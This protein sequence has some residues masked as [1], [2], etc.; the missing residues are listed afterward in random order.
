MGGQQISARGLGSMISDKSRYSLAQFLEL[1]EIDF[2]EALLKK[3][4]GTYSGSGVGNFAFALQ[5][6]TEP[7]LT[8]LLSEIVA[9][10]ADLR[11]RVTP[12]R[13]DQR[14]DDLTRCLAADHV[15]VKG[16]SLAVHSPPP[17]DQGAFSE[18]FGEGFRPMQPDDLSPDRS[19]AGS[20]E[21]GSA[22]DFG[23]VADLV[24]EVMD[25]GTLPDAPLIS[26]PPFEQR[27]SPSIEGVAASAVAAPIIDPFAGRGLTGV[28][29]TGVV[30]SFADPPPLPAPKEAAPDGKSGR[31]IETSS[32]HPRN[33][34]AIDY[35]DDGLL[36][37]CTIC[38]RS[39]KST[40]WAIFPSHEVAVDA[41]SAAV[42]WDLGGYD[43]AEVHPA[44]KA[45]KGTKHYEHH[46]DWLFE[47]QLDDPPDPVQVAGLLQDVRILVDAASQRPVRGIGDNFPPSPIDAPPITLT[48]IDI[49]IQA[50]NVYRTVTSRDEEQTK[51]LEMVFR[52]TAQQLEA[53]T[54]WLGEQSVEF[55]EKIRDDAGTM[56]AE[57]LVRSAG[58]AACGG[59]FLLLAK[60][61]NAL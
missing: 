3:H 46:A 39:Q 51:L 22:Y 59:A 10:Q 58:P 9:T 7:Y 16:N 43:T 24:T 20:G 49:C 55:F 28:S 4:N 48:D 35:V 50:V 31:W 61:L 60:L 21:L 37:P 36:G 5:G 26:N 47:G 19:P 1:Q 38:A 25:F 2:V 33:G 56:L 54:T 17:P 40:V 27:Q 30:A 12:A 45:P 57:G 18:A 29:A 6:L 23:S 53:F 52:K 14:F 34:S 32:S 8:E 42:V 13:F 15:M 44:S 11:A 41:A